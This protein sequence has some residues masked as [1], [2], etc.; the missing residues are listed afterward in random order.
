VI[1]LEELLE[2]ELNALC[3]VKYIFEL[4]IETLVVA[5]A[6]LV[7]APITGVAV[8]AATWRPHI[9]TN[10]LALAIIEWFERVGMSTLMLA[11][12]LTKHR[13]FGILVRDKPTDGSPIR[14]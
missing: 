10:T 8:L 7:A 6:T 4:N 12:M 5:H 2:L 13:A 3:D 9:C 14:V 11:V 1:V